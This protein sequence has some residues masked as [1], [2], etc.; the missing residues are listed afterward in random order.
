MKGGAKPVE[1]GG[2]WRLAEVVTATGGRLL[3][4][5]ASGG[6]SGIST[7]TR[8]LTPGDLFVA[9]SGENFDGGAFVAEAVAKG[10]AGVVVAGEPLLPLAVPVVVVADTLQALGDLAAWRR[11]RMVGL[12]VIGI[13]GS[14]G[15]TTVKEM[16]ASILARQ[17]TILK[18]GGNFNNLVGLP[19]TLLPVTPQH[20]L[21]VL[22]MGMNRPGEIARLTEI[23]APDLACIT[24]IQGAHLL[25]L[26]D[27]GGVARAK[28]ELFAGLAPAATMVVNLD[29]PLV[30]ALV[31]RYAQKKITF[32]LHRQAQVRAT[33]VRADVAAGIA[34]TLNIGAEKVRVRLRCL[35]RHNVINAL[36]AAALA[37]GA[38]AG[39]ADIAAGLAAFTPYDKRFQVEE[40][41]EG[42][43]VVNDTY[44]ANPS[45]MLAA[46]AT[47]A[48]QRRGQRAVAVLGDMLELGDEAGAAH[49]EIGA[50]VA[51]LGFAGLFAYGDM[52]GEMVAAARAAGM[53]GDCCRAYHDKNEIVVQLKKLMQNGGLAV[54]DWLLVKGSRG[55]KMET[56]IGALKEAR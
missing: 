6:F 18:T 34:F 22:E 8:K 2:A 45:S 13:T 21:A 55:M 30:R 44:N 19:L 23:A 26:A 47:V 3:G 31:G 12:R 1:S 11:R 20:Q 46:L 24:N 52:A 10:A 15:K 43:R 5:A 53:A 51:R 32:G 16:T 28:E 42:V 38:G 48:E 25:G 56:V 27:I 29:D 36:A 7:D 37:H 49:R 40:L 14:S 9:L 33:Y 50:A 54:G 4:A 17:Y 39:L 35:G 41:P